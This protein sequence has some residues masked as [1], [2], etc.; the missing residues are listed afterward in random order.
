MDTLETGAKNRCVIEATHVLRR[1]NR[2]L[3]SRSNLQASETERRCK[4]LLVSFSV[5][6]GR[7]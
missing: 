3:I 7:K 2:F 5:T 1:I 4:R 6:I